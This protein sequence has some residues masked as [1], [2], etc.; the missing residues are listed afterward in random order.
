MNRYISL[1]PLI[2]MLCGG[3]SAM[4][5]LFAQSDD[6]SDAAATAAAATAMTPIPAAQPVGQDFCARVAAAAGDQAVASGFDAPTQARMRQQSYQQC[7]AMG[8]AG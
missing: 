7:A 5:D 4:P 6:P 1:V 2:A 8:S 3:C